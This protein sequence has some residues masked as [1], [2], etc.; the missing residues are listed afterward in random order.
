MSVLFMREAG[1]APWVCW[2]GPGSTSHVGGHGDGPEVFN[3]A[4][5]IT[6]GGH[7]SQ[8]A[9][10]QPSEERQRWQCGRPREASSTVSQ[11]TQVADGTCTLR[12]G[13]ELPDSAG[14]FPAGWRP[15]E[16]TPMK[17]RP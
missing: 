14:I 5:A 4:A 13:P 16:S 7:W 3:K 12:E 2:C 9:S 1:E 6:C 15:V 8:R 17:Q 10:R 11:R